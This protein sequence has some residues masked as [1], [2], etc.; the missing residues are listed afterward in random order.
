MHQRRLATYLNDRAALLTAGAELAGRAAISNVHSPYGPLFARAVKD[1]EADRALLREI[2]AAHDVSP[3]RLKSGAAWLGEKLGRLKPNDQLTGYSPLSRVVELDVLT[4]VV[5]TL[6]GTWA[7][8]APLFGD[9]AAALG[10]ARERAQR[11]LD[12]LA[13]L[14]PKAVAA[15]VA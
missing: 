5:A 1:F 14:R 10:E 15:A 9:H 12:E 8:L 3:D 11:T 4:A 7:A 2:M 6:D 13:T